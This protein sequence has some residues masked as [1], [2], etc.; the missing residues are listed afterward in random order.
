MSSGP[1]DPNLLKPF[2]GT[3][4][5]LEPNYQEA[6][7]SWKTKPDKASTGH[8]LRTI[9]PSID[10]AIQAHVGAPHPLIQSRARSIVLK[11]LPKYD[12]SKSALN[13]YVMN[14]LYSLRRANRQ[15][16]QVVSMPER[17]AHE[18]GTL[19]SAEANLGELLGREPTTAELADHSGVSLRRIARLR[20]F[21][22]PLAEGQLE[23]AA[24]SGNTSFD[25]RVRD[26]SEDNRWAD[27]IYMDL[28]PTDQ[29]I[30]E[31]TLGMYGKPVLQNQQIANMLGLSAGAVSQRKAKIQAQ[32][33]DTT[34]V[35]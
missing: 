14:Q 3:P 17:W 10:R 21:N 26:S 19:A 11:S 28:T 6:Y 24:G 4:A 1:Q 7:D 30:M 27:V 31:H 32:M 20:S 12:A 25:P 29:K 34:R 15:Q 13:T 22:Q 18:A 8:L 5:K 23:A 9:Q 16:T 2:S 33:A 35:F